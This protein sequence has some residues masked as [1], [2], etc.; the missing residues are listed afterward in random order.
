VFANEVKKNRRKLMATTI[1]NKRETTSLIGSDKVE[2]TAVYGVDNQKIGSVK[3][4]M[5]DK[6]SGK[7]AYAVVSFGGFL[8]IGEDYYP[9]PWSKLD[10]DTRLGGYK[11]D[12][13]EAQ[14]RSAPKFSKHQEWDWSTTND[15][16]V[17]KY[18]NEPL[19]YE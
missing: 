18:Y 1:G 2:G 3:R 6:I 4:V 15:E 12:L 13:T 16:R 19:W 14:L 10:Y 8:G 17:Y 7:V 5:I 9:M 11:T